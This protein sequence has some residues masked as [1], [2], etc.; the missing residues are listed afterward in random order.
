M[1]FLIGVIIS[2]YLFAFT[3]AW[4]VLVTVC[5]LLCCAVAGASRLATLPFRRPGQ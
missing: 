5:W 3:L 1:L 2:L 4:I